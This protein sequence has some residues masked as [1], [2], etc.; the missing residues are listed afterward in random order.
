MSDRSGIYKHSRSHNTHTYIYR[1]TRIKEANLDNPEVILVGNKS[2][3]T[4]SRVITKEQGMELAQS[5]GIEY[6]ETSAKDG[7]NVAEVVDKLLDLIYGKPE[8]K[9]EKKPEVIPTVETEQ[10]IEQPIEKPI[11]QPIEKPVKKESTLEKKPDPEKKPNVET[12]P[13]K[14]T[15]QPVR[16][17]ATKSCWSTGTFLLIGVACV[18]A[19]SA[20]Y[21]S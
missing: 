1:M 18:V 6:F 13:E 8:P 16:K 20:W 12:I 2:D 15:K 7:M 19:F 17:P 11:E 9:P 4:E 14:P 21:F 3:L 5:L 10:A